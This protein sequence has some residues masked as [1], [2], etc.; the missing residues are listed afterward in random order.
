MRQGSTGSTTAPAERWISL[1]AVCGA[2]GMVWL[3]FSGLAVAI[4]TLAD[5]FHSSMTTLQWANNAFSLVTGALVIAGGRFADLFGRRLMLQVGTLLLT[6][7]SVL[8]ALAPTAAW[9]IVGRGLMGI[10]AALVLPASLA[11]I[12]REFSGRAEVAAFGVWQAVA[13]GGLSVGPAISGALTDAFGWQWLFWINIPLAVVTLTVVRLTTPE[14]RDTGVSRH[15]DVPG[16]AAVGL[17]VFALLYALTEGPDAG[18]TSPLTVGLLAAA[19]VLT[20]A[21]IRI[22]RRVRRPLVDLKLFRIR[23]YDGAL[24]ANLAMNVLYAGLSFLLV[25]WL[26]NV[27][28]YDPVEAGALLLPAT[29]GVFLCIPLGGRLENRLGG[30]P[31]V[32]LGL[33]LAAVGL[34]GLGALGDDTT[35][36]LLAGGLFVTGLGLG[37]VSTPVADTAVGEVPADLSGTAAGVFKMSS[38]LGGALGVAGFSAAARG[39]TV[40]EG[41]D[42]VRASGLSQEE[43]SQAKEALVNSSS[44]HEAIASLPS[45]IR[46]TVARVATEAFTSGVAGTMRAAAVVGLVAAVA[47]FF[48]WPRGPR[49]AR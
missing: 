43:V 5:E 40:R 35:T 46:E 1:F 42:V 23:T 27:R 48:V 15:I 9:L 17:A 3:A 38:M 36:W 14:S 21:W 49:R 34:A 16:L 22:E 25:L 31:P 45:D 37:L 7:F 2:A 10:G 30:R 24:T 39:I 6:A 13:W 11:L 26:Q 8:A 4:P 32:V 44:F 28:G 19:V 20:A 18:W 33:F 41:D 47:V 12:P 29:A